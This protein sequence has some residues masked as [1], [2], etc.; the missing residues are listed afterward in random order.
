MK[1]KEFGVK[2]YSGVAHVVVPK[3]LDRDTYIQNCCR[4]GRVAILTENNE[5]YP[6]ARVSKSVFNNIYFPENFDDGGSLLFWVLYPETKEPIVVG[7]LSE[8]TETEDFS[9]GQFLLDKE[10]TGN[11]VKFVGDAKRAISETHV[12]GDKAK[13]KRLATS[14]KNNSE[15]LDKAD[16]IKAISTNRTVQS[17]ITQIDIGTSFTL[18][19]KDF[20]GEDVF[21]TISGNKDSLDLE[22]GDSRVNI[23]KNK[24][25]VE[26]GEVSVKGASGVSIAS[27]NESLK[28]LLSDFINAVGTGV[29]TSGSPLSTAPD[30]LALIPKLQSLLK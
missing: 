7:V 25:T 18:R 17:K 12:F 8:A 4:T 23:V 1:R 30:I 29:A 6:K 26:S 19:I 27:E 28:E 15:I 11:L 3:D 10:H 5:F 14:P 2:Y 16:S 22:L 20:G 13:I 24:I 21:L 9:E